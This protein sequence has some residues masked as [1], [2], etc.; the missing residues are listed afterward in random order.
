MLNKGKMAVHDLYN[1]LAKSDDPRLENTKE[2]LLRTYNKSDNDKMDPV[3]MHRL[4]Y[5]IYA[6]GMARRIHFDKKQET[7]IQIIAD[8]GNRVGLHVQHSWDYRDVSQ[9]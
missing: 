8:I 2:V 1:S 9:F 5:F 6:E 3:L 7:Y 4:A